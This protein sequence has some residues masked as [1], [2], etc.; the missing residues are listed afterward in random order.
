MA[1]QG[2]RDDVLRLKVDRA[3]VLIATRSRQGGET[4]LSQT[5][6]SVMSCER[7]LSRFANVFW[8]ALAVGNA[9]QK[10]RGDDV[11][12]ARHGEVD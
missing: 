2:V 1:K 11:A 10:M 5:S 3:A 6:D 4:L 7:G 12:T 9:T 8:V